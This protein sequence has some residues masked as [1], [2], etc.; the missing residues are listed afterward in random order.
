V[1]CATAVSA[2]PTGP[3]TVEGSGSCRRVP[4]STHGTGPAGSIRTRR[5]TPQHPDPVRAGRSTRTCGHTG[6][7]DA[8]GAERRRDS[9]GGFA[10][11]SQCCR[12]VP[13][14]TRISGP[15]VSIG[16]CRAS[17]PLD[18]TASGPV[19]AHR[20]IRSKHG[21]GTAARA[22]PPVRMLPTGPLV[23]ARNGTSGQHWDPSAEGRRRRAASA[24][25]RGGAGRRRRR[26]PR[27]AAPTASP[28]ESSARRARPGCPRGPR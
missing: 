1:D 6:G 21:A 5:R 28:P 25:R 23:D 16:N 27:A 13:S 18:A 14:S 17:W 2:G 12:Q 26:R 20:S 4:F 10:H 22:S 24:Q 8:A 3:V 11:R 9:S 15:A 7:G 19:G